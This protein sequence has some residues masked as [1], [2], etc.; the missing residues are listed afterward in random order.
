MY[1][2]SRGI[3]DPNQITKYWKNQKASVKGKFVDPFLPPDSNSLEAK[4]KSGN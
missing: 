3:F 4:D 1:S 2:T